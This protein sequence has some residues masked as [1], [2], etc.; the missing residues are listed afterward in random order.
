MKK[1]AAMAA[2]VALCLVCFA[3]CSWHNPTIT[4]DIQSVAKQ[5]SKLDDGEQATVIVTGS[6]DPKPL[7]NEGYDWDS[8][9]CVEMASYPYKLRAYV[10]HEL[11][12][13]ETAIINSGKFTVSGVYTAEADDGLHDPAHKINENVFSLS[14]CDIVP[15]EMAGALSLAAYIIAAL[16]LE[17][18]IGVPALMVVGAI[19]YV[20]KR[21]G[22][23]KYTG[24]II[25]LTVFETLMLSIFLSSVAS[26]YACLV[27]AIAGAVLF[28]I[29]VSLGGK[30][31]A[32]R[33]ADNPEPE[34]PQQ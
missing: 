30:D 28:Y 19:C 23:A 18:F 9:S 21:Q 22:K 20:R 29:R 16:A 7:H 1:I 31:D 8:F 14:D 6:L 5:C 34:K 2:A 32:A 27:L 24:S 26:W 12:P 17:V 15:M 3:G 13:D 4:G 11:T 10:Y 33:T 25:A